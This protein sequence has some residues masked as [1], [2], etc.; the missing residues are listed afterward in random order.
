MVLKQTLDGKSSIE[1]YHYPREFNLSRV[2]MHALTS[3]SNKF[4]ISYK[5]FMNSVSVFGFDCPFP[6]I[7]VGGYSLDEEFFS[8][9]MYL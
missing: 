5:E 3:T 8:R 7:K 2:Y 4:E 1:D 6:Y 9:N